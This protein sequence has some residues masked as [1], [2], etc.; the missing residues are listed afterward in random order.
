MSA[1][2]IMPVQVIDRIGLILT[3][4]L[5]LVRAHLLTKLTKLKS[6]N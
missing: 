5:A 1:G 6:L 3:V 2:D 4:P